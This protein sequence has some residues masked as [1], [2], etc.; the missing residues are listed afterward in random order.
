[1]ARGVKKKSGKGVGGSKKTTT[2]K[3]KESV[4]KESRS[5]KYTKKKSSGSS[6]STSRK[7]RSSSGSTKTL[8]DASNLSM[9]LFGVP[10]QFTPL[11]DPRV[12]GISS[13]VG[14]NF[15]ENILLEAQ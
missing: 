6:S 8:R 14:K 3:K 13:E 4:K 15:T 5:K 2:S 1:M 10:Y 7:R 9:R 11:V 12:T